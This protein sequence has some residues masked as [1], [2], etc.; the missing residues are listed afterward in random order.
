MKKVLFLSF[1]C[2][3]LCTSCQ[4]ASKQPIQSF[5][6]ENLDKFEA[7]SFKYISVSSDD[8]L[9]FIYYDL[10][11]SGNR[12]WYYPM[13]ATAKDKT[14][15]HVQGVNLTLA[16]ICRTLNLPPVVFETLP[17]KGK[18][19]ELNLSSDFTDRLP[20]LNAVRSVGEALVMTLTEF[21]GIDS[22]QFLIDG[23]TGNFL[24]RNSAQFEINLPVTRPNWPNEESPKPDQKM[25]F[26]WTLPGKNIL[27]PVTISLALRDQV[28]EQA[29]KI[30]TE[31]PEKYATQFEP[32]VYL[33]TKDITALFNVIQHPEQ[34]SKVFVDFNFE[35]EDQKQNKDF[36]ISLRAIIQT[37]T[38]IDGIEEVQ[39]LFLGQK[40]NFSIEDL[41]L[42]APLKRLFLTNP[43][44]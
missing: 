33:N 18:V 25:V 1:L 26:Y 8:P 15:L 38:E 32:S 21:E 28:P 10:Y 35:P 43:K 6:E 30:L 31:G 19:V 27:V 12:F 7:E 5:V 40:L 9:S 2:I 17:V 36:A 42:G 24:S 22:V 29:V 44:E 11:G 3:I 37:L 34:R 39:F 16:G 13:T 14:P 20:V 41:N 23:Q 4:P